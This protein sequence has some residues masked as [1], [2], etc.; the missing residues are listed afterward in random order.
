MDARIF[1]CFSKAEDLFVA[2]CRLLPFS[3]VEP[4]FFL[5]R[6]WRGAP[7][8]SHANFHVYSPAGFQIYNLGGGHPVTL[9]YFIQLVEEGL[10]TKV[11]KCFERER[12]G[13]ET[14]LCKHSIEFGI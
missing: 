8:H 9:A 4:R 3:P 1:Q 13:G 10:K 12:K 14:R 2:F 11:P 6:D 7:T 5:P